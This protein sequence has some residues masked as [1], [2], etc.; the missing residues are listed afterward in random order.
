[1]YIIM[2]V[3]LYCQKF[4]NNPN[5]SAEDKGEFFDTI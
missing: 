1:M 2:M 4:A 5:I 3:K